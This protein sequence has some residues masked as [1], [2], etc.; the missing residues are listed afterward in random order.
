MAT[1]VRTLALEGSPALG[2]LDPEGMEPASARAL[3][4]RETVMAVI[5]LHIVDAF[6]ERPFAGNPAAIVP[7]AAA[8]DEEDMARVSEELGLEVGFVLPPRERGAD[9]RLRFFL[10]RNEDTLSGHVLLAALV[11]LVDRG[12]VR[13]APEGRRLHV[14]TL[15][16]VFAAKLVG[17]AGS[18]LLAEFEM[19]NPRFGE[20]VPVD[21]VA[22]TLDVPAELLRLDGAGPQR[23]SCGFDQIIV[24]V[25]DRS[26]MR[27]SLRGLD[28][29]QV[30]LDERGAAG[31][32]LLCPETLSENAHF[33][34]RFLHP[35]DRRSEDAASGTCIA[36]VAAYAV[37]HG[38]VPR[39]DEVRVLTEQGHLLGRPTRAEA[40]VRLLGDRIERVSLLGT[41]AVAMR[42]TLQLHRPERLAARS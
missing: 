35:G 20:P 31:L 26:V 23:V 37:K 17:S 36:A 8:L 14:E 39:S 10:E 6:A 15:A 29:I 16:G 11:S 4:G 38:L 25:S 32:V 3:P 5:P 42:G 41:G 19:P 1:V 28:R 34:C 13:P 24:P 18:P 30:L 22:G 7:N 40:R 9:L 12:I 2:Y 21:E 33:Q 27:G